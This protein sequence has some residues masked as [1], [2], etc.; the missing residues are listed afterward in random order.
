[1]RNDENTFSWI[2]RT[3]QQ[4]LYW[5]LRRIVTV[6][7]DAEDILQETFSKAYSHLWTLRNPEALKGWLF[8]I[9]T[10]EA[11]RYFRKRH[12]TVEPVGPDMAVDGGEDEMLDAIRLREA[13]AKLPGA[14]AKLSVLQREVFCMKYYEDMDYDRIGRITGASRN[15]LMVTYH[16]AKERIKKEIL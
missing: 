13:E 15:T 6:H 9:A 1:M 2:V 14:I 11:N 3:Y 5:Y 7:E 4:P 10:N 12:V 8:R 16:N